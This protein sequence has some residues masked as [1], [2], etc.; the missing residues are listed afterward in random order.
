[1][2]I[3]QVPHGMNNPVNIISDLLEQGFPTYGTRTTR[4]T[5]TGAETLFVF[6]CLVILTRKYD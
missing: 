2:G 1:M 4:G 3:K 6:I 5:W